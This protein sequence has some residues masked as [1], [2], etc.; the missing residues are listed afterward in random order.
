MCVFF[1]TILE[2]TLGNSNIKLHEIKI[3]NEIALFASENNSS[4]AISFVY[5]TYATTLDTKILP[6][7]KI[8]ITLLECLM[9]CIYHP[10]SQRT[11]C[12]GICASI[13]PTLLFLDDLEQV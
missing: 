3:D 1:H 12:D 8:D 13:N 2:C 9:N 4:H 6:L 7:N 11:I 10:Y 5:R